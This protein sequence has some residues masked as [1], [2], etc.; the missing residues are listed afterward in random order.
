VEYQDANNVQGPYLPLKKTRSKASGSLFVALEAPRRLIIA[1]RF[2]II[3]IIVFLTPY[4][5]IPVY[6]PGSG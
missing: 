3:K 4:E 5:F 1:E 6:G 2:S